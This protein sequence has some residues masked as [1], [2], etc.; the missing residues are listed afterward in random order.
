MAFQ[1]LEQLETIIQKDNSAA[2]G[3]CQY[4]NIVLSYL[5]NIIKKIFSEIK[6]SELHRKMLILI[7]ISR[8]IIKLSD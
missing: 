2:P 3:H 6:H 8:N 4:C 7:M 5:S 1:K